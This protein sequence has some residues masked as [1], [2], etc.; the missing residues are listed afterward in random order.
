LLIN[1]TYPQ[2]EFRTLRFGTGDL[3]MKTTH[4]RRRRWGDLVIQHGVVGK[5]EIVQDLVTWYPSPRFQSELPADFSFAMHCLRS[6]S[7]SRRFVPA[8]NT[9]DFI[10]DAFAGGLAV[11]AKLGRLTE[12]GATDCYRA[13]WL[14]YLR[15]RRSQEL[16]TNRFSWPRSFRV[17]PGAGTKLE[18]GGLILSGLGRDGHESGGV[19]SDEAG[20]REWGMAELLEQ[21]RQEARARSVLHPSRQDLLGLGLFRAARRNPLPLAEP[22]A[23]ASLL[24][25]AL[26]EDLGQ[27][28]PDLEELVT[29][30]LEQLLARTKGKSFAEF[31]RWFYGAKNNLI[32][33]LSKQQ[34]VAGRQLEKVEVRQV[35]QNL[36]WRAYPFVAD[37]VHAMLLLFRQLLPE[38]LTSADLWAY[39]QFYLKQPHFG[40]VPVLLFRERLPQLRFALLDLLEDPE[41]LSQH[42]GVLHRLLDY[43]AEMA[44]ARRQ[45]DKEAKALGR[46]SVTVLVE[47]EDKDALADPRS[48]PRASP[49]N[50]ADTE[51]LGAIARGAARIRCRCLAGQEEW[52]TSYSSGDGGKTMEFDFVC[53]R[54][55]TSDQ[56]KLTR[57]QLI[58]HGRERL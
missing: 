10:S 37:C 24:R 21:G 4:C 52:E 51:Q 13:M 44:V 49:A 14:M 11:L 41:D 34:R 47:K 28:V 1:S 54:C 40:H 2:G 26:F 50:R 29:S 20:N 53:E 30:K 55:G 57:D 36:G 22:A 8:G 39:D 9:D 5:P 35:L 58:A 31:E 16:L 27:E 15:V 3:A 46:H 18:R 42:A 45:A 48:G 43:F 6:P 38:P 12:A 23:V 32:Q 25:R 33:V 17:R 56:V 7:G 19:A